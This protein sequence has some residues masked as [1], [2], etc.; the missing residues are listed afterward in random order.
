MLIT[1]ASMLLAV[2][3]EPA[4]FSSGGLSGNGPARAN[5]TYTSRSAGSLAVNLAAVNTTLISSDGSWSGVPSVEGYFGQNLAA[6][7]GADPQT[8]LT[9]E[10]ARHTLPNSP[11]NV[12]ANKGNPSAFNAGGI[13]EF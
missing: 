6:T 2:T 9:T 7:H 1:A 10:F 4:T 11:T 8:V 5:S 12:S 13:A 3:G